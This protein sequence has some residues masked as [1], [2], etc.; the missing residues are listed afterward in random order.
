MDT[1]EDIY[2][3]NV[4]TIYRIC[5]LYVKNKQDTEDLVQNIFLKYIN[6]EI[7]FENINHEKAWFIKVATNSCKNHIK[8]Y[9]N[10]KVD[11]MPDAIEF[12]IT[13]EENNILNDVL[14]LPVKYK[15]VIYMYYYEGYSINEISE[16][17]K[18]NV[19]TLKTRLSKGRLL[20]KAE[21]E[22]FE[23]E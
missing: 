3:R 4:D 10:R 7:S 18:T 19:S 14:N 11:T 2:N 1:F 12:G 9:W 6:N 20:L 22:R 8:S 13:I 21:I 15:Q 17:L 16:I 23:K 5:Y